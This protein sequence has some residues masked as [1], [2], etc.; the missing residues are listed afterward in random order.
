[1]EE[2]PSFNHSLTIPYKTDPVFLP[3]DLGLTSPF[4]LSPKVWVLPGPA[5]HLE[6]LPLGAEP[7]GCGR[8]VAGAWLGLQCLPAVTHIWGFWK[9]DLNTPTPTLTPIHSSSGKGTDTYTGKRGTPH[10]HTLHIWKS[11]QGRLR[12]AECPGLG[13]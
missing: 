3:K 4:S 2:S 13:K 5:G 8:R 12:G 11:P 10:T 1:M 6:E 9:S 7:P